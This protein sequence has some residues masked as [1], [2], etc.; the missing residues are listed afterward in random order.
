MKNLAF[1]FCIFL[2]VVSFVA[3]VS[4][5]FTPVDNYLINCGSRDPVVVDI[6]H[7]SFT[8]DSSQQG[9]RFLTSSA[10]S[11]PLTDA[12]PASYSSPLYRTARAFKSP[13]RYVFDIKDQGVHHFVRLHFSYIYNSSSLDFSSAK[14]HV[15][16]NGFLLL[17]DFS[18]EN[19]QKGSVIKEF[20]INIDV[21]KL[22]LI[23]A[24]SER[25]KFA[26]VNAVEVISA[27]KD[28]IADVAQYVDSGRNERIVGLLKNGFETVYRV[29]VGG[30][31]VTPFNDSLWRTWIP[32]DE[33][34]K[35]NEGS[36]KVHFGGRIGYRPGGASREV[37]PDNVYS[38]ARVIKSSDSSVPRLNITWMFP[39]IEAYNYLIRMHFCDIASISLNLLYF[40]VYVNGNL[41]YE[42]LDLSMITSYLLASPFYADFVVDGRKS[43]VLTVSVGPS[44]ASLP[45]SFDA[46]LNAVEILKIS[47]E[48]GSFDG[49]VCAESA[50]KSWKGRNAGILLPLLAAVFLLL[51]A[52]VIV[53][54]KSTS[55]RDAVGFSRLPI[56]VSK[57]NPKY[58]NQLSSFKH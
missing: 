54:R 13:S 33:Y 57:V 47:N 32:D 6:D 34:F 16:A 7:R 12:N 55:I 41:A 49:E 10:R 19:S 3:I 53:R 29:N 14:F 44:N 5:S 18:L 39:G 8:G 35:S 17:R 26:F 25:S 24:P 38:S 21:G 52:S 30:P 23:F 28:L 46:I 36:S 2:S 20:I 11:I 50:M 37:G 51:T 42:N 15:I 1:S 31:K 9:S 22:E 58:G 4:S 56:D 43:G 45:H 40:N 27:P 48:M